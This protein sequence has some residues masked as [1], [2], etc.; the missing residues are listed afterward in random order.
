MRRILR[1]MGVTLA[2]AVFLGATTILILGGN[3][4]RIIPTGKAQEVG[5]TV[6]QGTADVV[7]GGGPWSVTAGGFHP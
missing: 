5:S 4:A 7:R 6:H 2:M 3:K 1:L